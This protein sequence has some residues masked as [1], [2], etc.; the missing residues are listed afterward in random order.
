MSIGFRRS[1]GIVAL[2]FVSVGCHQPDVDVH[3][4]ALA[5]CAAATVE[6]SAA[7]AYAKGDRV[8]YAGRTYQSL[9]AHTAQRGWEPP[10]VPALW[11]S[12]TPC[13]VAPW[14]AQTLYV[15]GSRVTYGGQTYECRQAHQSQL[16]WEP[17]HVPALWNAIGPAGS[18]CP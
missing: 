12:P 9:S 8:L 13:D 18:S 7:H 3:A 15:V 11:A 14:V 1:I 17:P 6:W 16:G 2:A 5:S 10:N 4:A